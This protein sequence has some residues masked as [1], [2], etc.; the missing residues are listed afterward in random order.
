MLTV[1]NRKDYHRV[2]KNKIDRAKYHNYVL[3]VA[4]LILGAYVT[5]KFE[6][7][8]H[9]FFPNQVV[10]ETSRTIINNLQGMGQLVTVKAEVA[11][12]D[13]RISIHRGILDFG[14]YSA[15]H[16][17]VGVIEAGIDF[18]AINDE[19]V[20]FA[21]DAY[22]LI[23]PAPII[24]SCRI[25]HID[26][27]EYSFTLLAADWDTVRQ[28]AQHEAI[29]Q[30]AEE[31]IENGILERAKEET[32]IRIGDFVSNLSGKLVNIEYATASGEPVKPPSCEPDAPSGWEKDEN[33][34][35]RRAD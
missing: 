31:M 8:R 2:E 30:F 1:A 20:R 12:T 32:A 16:I 7:I 28:L 34:G 33:G 18:D 15:N 26:Q 19:S 24:T 6:S 9:T 5:G 11:K 29:V 35:W 14:Y 17:A 22:T 27:N 3:I 13:V 25:E 4:A 23:L 21:N 10:V